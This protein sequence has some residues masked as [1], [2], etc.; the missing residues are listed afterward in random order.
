MAEKMS[1]CCNAEIVLRDEK[2]VC[3]ACEGGLDYNKMPGEDGQVVRYFRYQNHILRAVFD[4][5][6]GLLTEIAL[7]SLQGPALE[8]EGAIGL[9]DSA[10]RAEWAKG[11][12]QGPVTPEDLAAAGITTTTGMSGRKDFWAKRPDFVAHGERFDGGHW[13]VLHVSMAGKA[14]Y[15]IGSR[16]TMA[17]NNLLVTLGYLYTELGGAPD[18]GVGRCFPLG[19]EIFPKK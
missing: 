13:H 14:N 17:C 2:L 3:S 1:A 5:P 4:C 11:F 8:I 10:L 18:G 19:K 7:D 15:G 9:V 6:G 16:G 12:A